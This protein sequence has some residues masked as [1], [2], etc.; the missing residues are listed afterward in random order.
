MVNDEVT[1]KFLANVLKVDVRSLKNFVDEGM[2]KAARGK[3]ALS[4]C[5]PWYVERERQ[6]ARASRGLN[7]L[8]LAR[9]R[10]T[11]AEAQAEELRVAKLFASV[12]DNDVHKEVVA[13]I[14]DRILAILQNVPGNYGLHL[15]KAGVPIDKAEAVLEMI[16]TEMTV[17]LRTIADSLDA[18]ADREEEERQ[19]DRPAT[20][21]GA[22]SRAS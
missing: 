17:E 20:A 11:V 12:I 2:P 7:D 16:A 1:A 4:Q 3:Y 19:A 18:D 14:N 9:Q 15:E 10:K 13:T 6:A 5:V 21:A 22:E 8:D